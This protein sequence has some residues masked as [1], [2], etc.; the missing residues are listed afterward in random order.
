MPT[1]GPGRPG[2]IAAASVPSC[3]ADHAARPRRYASLWCVSV[4]RLSRTPRAGRFNKIVIISRR[5]GPFV[6]VIAGEAIFKINCLFYSPGAAAR[7][8]RTV[9][10]TVSR[11]CRP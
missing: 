11:G 8:P 1:R 2:V 3:P 7:G 10:P 4:G 5:A 6:R 9:N